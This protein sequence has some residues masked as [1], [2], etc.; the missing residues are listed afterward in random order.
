L[1]KRQF[2][3]RKLAKIA[4]NWDHNI[5]PGCVC[6]K[7]AQNVAQPI[8]C[9]NYVLPH[10]YHGKKDAQK[11][12]LGRLLAEAELWSEPFLVRSINLSCMHTYIYTYMDMKF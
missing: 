6:D 2:L 1:R 4:E 5:D 8:F 12:L 11:V 9:H 10:F 3:R 7:I